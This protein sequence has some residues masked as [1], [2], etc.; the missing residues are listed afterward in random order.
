[1][2]FA[3]VPATRPAAAPLFT[4]ADLERPRAFFRA[5]PEL[6]PTPLH[7]CPSL[8]RHL[9]IAA[10]RVKDETA[11]FGLNAFKATGALFAMATLLE[12]G[13][14]RR[15]DTVVCASEGNHGR[16]VARAAREHGCHAQV[17]MSSSVAGPRIAAIEG[18]GATVILVNGT[19]DDAVRE[20]AR[21]ASSRG[22]TIVS[23]TS[24][25]GYTEIPRLIMLGYTRLL[26]E[27]D[28]RPDVIVVPAGVGGLLAAVACWCELTAKGAGGRRPKV[29]AVEPVTAACVQA[30]VRAGAP[31]PVP[32][33][34]DSRM[35][36]LRCGEMSPDVFPCVHSLVDAYVAIE[37]DFALEA[38]RLLA[39]PAAP[40]PAVRCGASGAAALGGLLALRADSGLAEVGRQLDLAEARVAV[41]VTE[42]VTD[43]AVF[44]EALARR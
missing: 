6:G 20:M 23:D 28:D 37:D 3:F 24:W 32:G 1:M 9:G 38:I 11:R 14:L 16:A 25:P 43:P 34:F 29:V 36:G 15:G 2:P 44:D 4:L 21:V 10:L 18:E 33:P 8:A 30:S 19:Y 7:R 22:W 31:T 13:D 42:G 41:L 35:G 27:F 26:D 17:F 39:R 5:R 40:D 12:R